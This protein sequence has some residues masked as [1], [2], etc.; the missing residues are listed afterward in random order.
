MLIFQWQLFG[1][2]GCWLQCCFLAALGWV[3]EYDRES[4]H[5]TLW[6]RPRQY[7]A[8]FAMI[9]VIYCCQAKKI[10]IS[11]HIMSIYWSVKTCK[12][13]MYITCDTV[14]PDT[15]FPRQ[16]IQAVSYPAVICN[17]VDLS[18]QISL[19]CFWFCWQAKATLYFSN[20]P[21]MH[22]RT[23]NKNS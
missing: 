21:R 7:S 10:M 5:L 2:D 17:S 8:E 23:H 22:T 15:S 9:I 4:V 11:I 1:I 19:S 14:F 18:V 13:Y 20:T 16:F 6:C 12:W 3:F